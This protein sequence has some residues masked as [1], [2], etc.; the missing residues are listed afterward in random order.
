MQIIFDS[1]KGAVMLVENVQI[2]KYVTLFKYKYCPL[3]P[4]EY[5]GLWYQHRLIIDNEV[6]SFLALGAQ[7]WV[8]KQD[9][10][11]FEW[12]WDKTGKYRNIKATTLQTS[13]KNGK[14]IVRGTRKAGAPWMLGKEG[15]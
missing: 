4:N 6:Y 11:S 12:D 1:N 8:F 9:T 7:R 15:V 13:N 5:T 2:E 10:V 3:V 14:E